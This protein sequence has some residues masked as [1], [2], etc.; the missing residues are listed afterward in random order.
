MTGMHR[1]PIQL[2]SLNDEASLAP[3]FFDRCR[4]AGPL[5]HGWWLLTPQVQDVVSGVSHRRHSNV[6]RGPFQGS[7]WCLS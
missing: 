2:W 6:V 7:G 4:N 3:G 1:C 5:C